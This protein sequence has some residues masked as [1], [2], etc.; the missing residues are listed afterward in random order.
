ML[1]VGESPPASGRFFYQADSGFYR[2]VRDSFVG[3]L[4]QFRKTEFLVLFRELSCYL[5]DLCERPVDR[6]SGKERRD[7]CQDGEARLSKIIAELQPEIIV[8]VVRSIAPNVRRA[9]ELA[10]WDGQSLE[11]PYPGRWKTHRAAFDEALR[12]LL[13]KTFR[14]D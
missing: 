5:V 10:K 9:Q 2:A 7:V 14:K 4:P 8:T 6:L 1:F 3:A 13:R 11:V 12:P